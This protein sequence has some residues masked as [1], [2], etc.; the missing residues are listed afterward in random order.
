MQPDLPDAVEASL[1]SRSAQ[2]QL[3]AF[4]VTMERFVA[5]RRGTSHRRDR[6][7]RPVREIAVQIVS[8]IDSAEPITQDAGSFARLEHLYLAHNRVIAHAHSERRPRARNGQGNRVKEQTS[9]PIG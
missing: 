7:R 3:R 1:L 8:A 6:D 2:A 5:N 4:S 9:N